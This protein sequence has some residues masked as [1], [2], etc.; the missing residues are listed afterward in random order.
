MTHLDRRWVTLVF[1]LRSVIVRLKYRLVYMN[2]DLRQ[3]HF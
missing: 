2:N 1:N 3:C